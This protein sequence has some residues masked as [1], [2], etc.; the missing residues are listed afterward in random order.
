[1]A[2]LG[3]K[4]PTVNTGPDPGLDR[5]GAMPVS[6][7]AKQRLGDWSGLKAHCRLAGFIGIGLVALATVS[8]R[9]EA[10]A[11][12]VAR[13]AQTLAREEAE[14]GRSS[15]YLL[16]V[17]GQLAVAQFRD[18]ALAEA[19]A[20]RRRALAIAIAA[21]G[22]DSP[23]TAETMAALAQLDLDR[24]R[25]LDAEPLLIVAERVLDRHSDRHAAALAELLA[26][27]A[28]LALARG[29]T[30]PAEAFARRAVAI[31]QHNPQY[32][33]TAPLQALAA[34]LIAEERF[35]AAEQPIAEALA[36]DRRRHGDDAIE[37]AR[38]LSLFAHL[39]LRQGRP[40]DALPQIETAA[41]IDQRRLASTHPFIADDF[42]DLGLVYVALK[43]EAAARHAFLA[44]RDVLE[45][46]AGRETPRVAY[47]ELE[48]AHLYRRLGEDKEADAA[49]RDARR[50]LNKAEAEEHRRE[51]HA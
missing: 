14:S 50:I 29:E 44:A 18:G 24:D 37:T 15:P 41:A 48:L 45:R 7:A 21:F 34:V 38:S 36:Q 43:R 23:D 5:T 22:C 35:A 20:L 6:V 49:F 9:A 4:H 46:G 2:T 31:A 25:Y 16:P 1:M 42:Y 47:V 19:A 32:R 17:I 51:R 33:S 3:R 26:D 11:G 27:R 10:D 39:R 12:A 13:L 28:R 8:P 30:A 40:R